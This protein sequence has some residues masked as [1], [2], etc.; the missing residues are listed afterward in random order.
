M[1]R[2]GRPLFPFLSNSKFVLESKIKGGRN[3]KIVGGGSTMIGRASSE[4]NLGGGSV[5]GTEE[6]GD[7][8]CFSAFCSASFANSVAEGSGIAS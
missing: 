5:G 4:R 1:V 7:N 8:S 6:N 3:G 2:G